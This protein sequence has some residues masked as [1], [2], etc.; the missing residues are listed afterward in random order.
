MLSDGELLRRYVENRDEGAFTVLVERH[1]NVVYRA[2]I[3]R[4]GGNA[5]AADDVTQRVF[6]ALA[7]KAAGLRQHGSL[8]GWLYT[9]TRFAA[10]ELVRAEQR[11]RKHEQEATTMEELNSPPSPAAAQI[12]P[13]LDEIMERLS[14][15][16]REVV[17]LHFFEGHSFVEIAGMLSSTADATRMRVNR[18]L[19]R[20]RAELARRGVAST[21]AALGTVLATESTIAA[22]TSLATTVAAMALQQATGA[23]ATISFAARFLSVVKTWPWL[24]GSAAVVVVATATIVWQP[25]APHPAPI[26]PVVTSAVR[27]VLTGPAPAERELTPESLPPV[28]TANASQ[29]TVSGRSVA[30]GRNRFDAL[31][32]A[33]KNIIAMLWREQ[34][35]LPRVAGIGWG[36]KVP[37]DAPNRPGVTSLQDRGLVDITEPK[38]VVHLTTRGR[39]FCAAFAAQIKAYEVTTAKTAP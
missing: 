37:E 30:P 16:D 18:A 33:E 7:R 11:R 20:M 24:A 22:P 21:A 31:S 5:H 1:I 19:E 6:T 27:D 4:V 17:L 36:L 35:D 26:S 3:R 28:A 23:A 13:V 9:S 8:A 38:G 15:R 39:A 25:A 2:A 14:P 29:S 10:A 34:Q 12:D 32:A